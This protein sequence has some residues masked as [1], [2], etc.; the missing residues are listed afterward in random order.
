[1]IKVEKITISRKQS[2]SI[3]KDVTVSIKHSPII[4]KELEE[5]LQLP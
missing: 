2:R 3:T 4:T 5:E 1:V